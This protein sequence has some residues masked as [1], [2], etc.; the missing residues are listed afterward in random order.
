MSA[1]FLDWK[2]GLQDSTPYWQLDQ[3]R[4]DQDTDFFHV[5]AISPATSLVMIN[6]SL[7]LGLNLQLAEVGR[8]GLA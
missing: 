7:F 8:R 4:A 6:A 5:C 2:R 3:A 1:M